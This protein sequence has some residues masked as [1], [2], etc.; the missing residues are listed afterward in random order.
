MLTTATMACADGG[1]LVRVR[2]I[3]SADEY[4]M[5]AH[6]KRRLNPRTWHGLAGNHDPIIRVDTCI[7]RMAFS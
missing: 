1:A 4:M 3:A 2:V 6:G 5:E 7:Q